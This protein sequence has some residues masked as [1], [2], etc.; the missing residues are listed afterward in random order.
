MRKIRTLIVDD[1]SLAREGLEVQL[2]TDAE[3]EVIGSC[4]DGKSAIASIRRLQPDLVILDVQ[5][6]A[7]DGFEV[8]EELKPEERPVVIFATAYDEHAIHAFE[9]SARDYLLKPFSDKRLGEALNRAKMAVRHNRTSEVFQKLDDWLLGTRADPTGAAPRPPPA[10]SAPSRVAPEEDD[11]IILKADGA[12]HFINAVEIVWI[13]AQGDY[14]RVQTTSRTQL[15]RKTLGTME[16]K[17]DPAKFVRVHRSYLVNLEF[18]RKVET[19]M[20]GDYLVFMVDGAKIRM[21]RN[22]RSRLLSLIKP[23]SDNE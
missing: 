10:I 19:A 20:Y 22:Y 7:L 17:L 1:E 11:R 4:A 5:M 13:E 16:K 9:V 14:V 3:I 23:K 2:S 8:L 12:F 18:V 21:S 15:V 6:P